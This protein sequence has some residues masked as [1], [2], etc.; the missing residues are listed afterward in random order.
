[1]IY[2]QTVDSRVAEPIC[3][4]IFEEQQFEVFWA[5]YP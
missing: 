5:T 1:M 2:Y 4:R 3:H